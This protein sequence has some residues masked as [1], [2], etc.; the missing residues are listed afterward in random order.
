VKIRHT[1]IE[2]VCLVDTEARSDARG[3]FARL[4]CEVTL[5]PLL[6]ARRIV[7]INQSKTHRAG[8]VRGMHFQHAPHAEMKLVR[9]VRG[10]VWDVAVDLRA[11]SPTFLHWHAEVL[12]AGNARMLV[13]P[14][15][16]A[17]GFQAM[18]PDSEM[19][20]LH[21][22]AYAPGAEGGVRFD[23]PLLGIDW[24]LAPTDVSARDTSHPW[25]DSAFAGIQT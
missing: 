23:D 15:G 2:G 9:C 21:T 25:L 19:L 17:H 4:F 7:Q 14:E 16:C 13:I 20:Y 1:A 10:S 12:S 24:P 11:G 8:V 3:A 6:G 18:E 5:A 22:A